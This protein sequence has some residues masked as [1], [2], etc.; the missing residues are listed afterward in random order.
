MATLLEI[1]KRNSAIGPLIEENLPLAPAWETVPVKTIKGLTYEQLVR[2][3]R[4]HGSFNKVG[5]GY[6]S[7]EGSYETKKFS[8][9]HWG[10]VLKVPKSYV[11][12]ETLQAGSDRQD[13]MTDELEGF[14]QQQLIDYDKQFFWGTDSGVSGASDGFAG[15]SQLVDSSMTFGLAETAGSWAYVVMENVNE[16]VSFLSLDGSTVDASPWEFRSDMLM[17]ASGTTITTAPGYICTVD[18][19]LGM[20]CVS[21]SK[22]IA[23]IKGITKATPLT[24]KV[25]QAVCS[26]FEG[27][28]QPTRIF[29]NKTTRFLLTSSRGVVTVARTQGKAPAQ[30][31]EIVASTA[32]ES[33][34]V[35]IAVTDSLPTN[36]AAPSADDVARLTALI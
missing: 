30:S 23:V 16:G 18:G 26:Q 27:S 35:P 7:T 8:L 22:T 20:K 13:Y 24:D 10:G 19:Y 28:Y 11:E 1:T 17:S 25:I 5:E 3:A 34:D 31:G 2:T 29:L 33:N 14:V 36:S 32:I 15:L 4:P 21:P 12:A 6:S 9:K